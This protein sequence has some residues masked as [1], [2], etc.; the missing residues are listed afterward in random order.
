M[1]IRE[2]PIKFA[3][4]RSFRG[5]IFFTFLEIILFSTIIIY[6]SFSLYFVLPFL[7]IFFISAILFDFTYGIV[8]L[9]ISIF[10]GKIELIQTPPLFY[11]DI[12]LTFLILLIFLSRA[13]LNQYSVSF[14]VPLIFLLLSLFLL[15]CGITL[16]RSKSF[17]WGI[18]SLR[19]LFSGLLVLVFIDNVII[20][21]NQIQKLFNFIIIWGLLLSIQIFVVSSREGN[22]QTDEFHKGLYLNWGRSNYLASFLILIIPMAYSLSFSKMQSY[23]KRIYYWIAFLMMMGALILT[24]SRGGFLAIV[25]PLLLLTK[26]FLRTKKVF[27]YF[28]VIIIP[29]IAVYFKEAF[30]YVFTGLVHIDKQITVLTRVIN[31]INSWKI[32][33]EHPL[34]GVGYGNLGYYIKNIFE[35]NTS[36]H[37]I[38]LSLLGETGIIGFI[39]FSCLFYQIIKIQL[40][41][42]KSLQGE[43]DHLMAWGVFAGTIGVLLHSLVEPSIWGYQMQILLWTV[44]GIAIKQFTLIERNYTFK[45][46]LK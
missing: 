8:F 16:Q 13:Y 21:K 2:I 7:F 15:Y 28:T 22:L 40:N 26:K 3:Q 43:E 20:G 29:F 38:V 46:M 35:K 39:I 10:F 33:L 11:I 45:T 24:G 30:L 12:I 31:W 19:Y 32:F 17:V 18:L 27:F 42:C 37:N 6:P 23:K 14:S 5:L 1:F 25:F 41:N 34:V 4:K 36:A 9:L 44:F